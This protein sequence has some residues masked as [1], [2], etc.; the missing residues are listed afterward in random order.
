MSY[1]SIPPELE[2]LQRPLNEIR[3]DSVFWLRDDDNPFFGCYVKIRWKWRLDSRNIVRAY[4]RDLGKGNF[5]WI[6]SNNKWVRDRHT[7]AIIH[8]LLD[9]L[10]D[11]YGWSTWSDKYIHR[12][13]LHYVAFYPDAKLQGKHLHHGFLNDAWGDVPQNNGIMCSH[14]EAEYAVSRLHWL[15]ASDD[16]PSNLTAISPE[17]HMLFHQCFH[18]SRFEVYSDF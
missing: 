8:L 10:K 3:T 4:R 16:T 15:V 5:C 12:A 2:A 17:A 7:I 11:S 9:R 13:A 1:K 18:D 6:W 14:L